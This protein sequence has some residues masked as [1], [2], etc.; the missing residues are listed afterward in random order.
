MFVNFSK[1]RAIW[2]D[3]KN[4]H[5][6]NVNN[7]TRTMNCEQLEMRLQRSNNNQVEGGAY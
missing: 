6:Q 1:R 2:A 7:K 3:W 5:L 4:L